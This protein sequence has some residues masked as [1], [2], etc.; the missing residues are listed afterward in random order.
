MTT[1]TLLAG[2]RSAI[3]VLRRDRALAF[4][5]AATL[6]VCIGAN[7]IVFSI[8]NSILIRPLPY[9]GSERID[10]ISE[11]SGPGR[12]DIGAAPDYYRIREGNGVFEEV[13]AFNPVALNW[14]GAGRP[15][16]L[17]AALVSPSFFRV[18]AMRPMLGRFLAPDEEGSKAAPVA[19][20]SYAFWRNRMGSD[21]H[22]IGKTI[23]LDRMA[24]TIIGVMPQ[25]F[26]F[27]RGAQAWLPLPFDE[28]SERAIAPN[29]PIFTVS[30]LGRRKPQLSA[31]E[32]E[33][34]LNR[35]AYLIRTEYKVFA[36]KFRW[37]LAIDATPLQKHLTGEI[38]PAVLVL[39]GAAA[40]ILLIGC[41]NL[42][43]LLLAGAG[44]RRR[45]MAVRMALGAGRARVIRQVLKESLALAAPGGLA[46][47]GI[48][49]MGLRWLNAAKP[50]ML[51]SY[52]PVSMDLTVLAFTAGLTLA[53]S[54]MFGIAPALSAP[55]VRIQ[56]TLKSAGA[57]HSEG[58][59][60][61][62]LR[63]L[64]IV[65]ELA[66]SLVLLTGAGL[67]GRTFLKLAHTE[68][69]FRAD[70]LLTFRATPAGPFDR[71]NSGF[72]AAVLDRLKRMPGVESAAIL[73]DIPLSGE[74]FDIGGRI[75][76][77]GR[78]A[79]PFNERP[80]IG[81]TAV[82]PEFFRTL[83]IPL[84]R[85]R[86][87]DSRDARR[88][89][90]AV[91]TNYGAVSA[92]RV[93]VNE[94]FVLRIFPGEDPVGQ[95]IAFGPDTNSV[96]WT[97]IGVAGDIRGGALGAEPAAMVY[98]CVFDGSRVG[99]AAFALRTKGDPRGEIHAVEEQV[100]AVDRDLPVFDV[101][102]ME[103]RRA[104]ALAPE[105]FQLALIG[106]FAGIAV[107]LAAAGVYGVVSYL[108]TRR[109]REIGIRVALG[110]RPADVLGMVVA[111]TMSLAP[112]AIC[113]GAGGAWALTRYLG[114][115]LYGVTEPDA[116]TFGLA[117]ALLAAVVLAACLAPARY[118][119][120]ID[121]TE[122]LRE[123]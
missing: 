51:A 84:K 115:M 32:V 14:T 120:R 83:G 49:W 45:E 16:Q 81:N 67:L 114:S 1:A 123:Q 60:A 82:S 104:A 106:G 11:R 80:I 5:A 77:V 54:V 30:L 24:R 103:E 97:I 64:L 73:T 94:A 50:A 112:A 75:R 105:E 26:D 87:F 85:G 92:A 65:L 40:L 15:E 113:A 2:A 13:A 29:R 78:P 95:R 55:A 7:T 47:I 76:V 98:R 58:V 108:V 35:L 63:K 37:D 70:H 41:V 100:H 122:A 46:G 91:L 117:S 102:T 48:A 18:M 42:A 119:A 9:P 118:A 4:S 52:P 10:W 109:I 110:A 116:G 27:P 22:A 33:R 19:V 21:L 34:D 38:R 121:P 93:M 56:E 57:A 66:V 39:S 59:R 23:A 74:D 61:A 6:A 28:S 111:E 44:S 62:S 36:T 99:R 79:A 53:A 43:N 72:Y 69:G 90:G 8:A 25:G 20:L 31:Q 86:V 68:P 12:E 107:L 88:Q 101:K 96:T 71:D 3:R 17:D 89:P